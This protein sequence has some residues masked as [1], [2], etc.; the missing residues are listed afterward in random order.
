M[1][2]VFFDTWRSLNTTH[3]FV[4]QAALALGGTSAARLTGLTNW[5]LEPTAAATGACGATS[6]VA[7]LLADLEAGVLFLLVVFFA[8]GD[9]TT[10][11]SSL[12]AGSSID[13]LVTDDLRLRG[14]V[15]VLVVLAASVTGIAGGGGGTELS[16][17]STLSWDGSGSLAFL[18]AEV[19]M[20]LAG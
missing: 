16:T 4:L 10:A 20:L 5:V 15:A 11:G 19:W 7:A 3:S 17:P 1:L 2:S 13:C 8:G 9:G 18:L 12:D 6:G 14:F